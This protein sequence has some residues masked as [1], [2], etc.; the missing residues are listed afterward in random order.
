MAK[1]RERHDR[2]PVNHKRKFKHNRNTTRTT[3]ESP[4]EY[5]SYCEEQDKDEDI[6]WIKNLTLKYKDKKLV[7]TQF[8]NNTRRIF[9]KE[10]NDIEDIVYRTA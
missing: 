7:I 4:V 2:R 8:N 10:L 6:I 3:S 1:N 9:F 5:I